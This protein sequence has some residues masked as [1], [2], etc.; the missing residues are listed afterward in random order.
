MSK[1]IFDNY[2]FILHEEKIEIKKKK[3]KKESL[4]PYLIFSNMLP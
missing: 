2:D 3:K 1:Y 4:P